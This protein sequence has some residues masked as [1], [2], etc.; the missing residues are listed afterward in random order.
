MDFR[1]PVVNL[2]YPVAYFRYPVAYCRYPVENF[3]YP[4]LYFRYPVVNK[5][6]HIVYFNHHFVYYRYPADQ[7]SVSGAARPQPRS[8]PLPNLLPPLT[9]LYS[10]L[11]VLHTEHCNLKGANVQY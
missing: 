11:K 8:W 7:H 1:Y 6:C 9:L 2:K 5:G 4:E 10:K 3:M